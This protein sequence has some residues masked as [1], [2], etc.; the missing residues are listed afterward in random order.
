M[1]YT[2]RV[3]K[4]E[5]ENSN[6]KGFVSITFDRSF[7][8]KNIALKESSKGNLYL[9]MP[10]FKDYQTE[11]YVSFYSFKDGD[12]RKA[13]TEQVI[14]AYQMI[15]A[16]KK[17]IDIE[18]TWDEEELYYAL[19]VTPIHGSNTFKAE[20]AIKI[21]DIFVVQQLR[22]IQGWNGKTFVGMPQ[23]ENR[24]KQEKED[25]AHPVNADFKK[26]LEKAIIDDYHNKLERQKQNYNHN[27][28][29]R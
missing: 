5:K 12:F 7:C 16:D 2:I 1:D 6:L 11:E 10:K 4:V 17:M 26:E 15:A 22:I 8:A 20:A 25:I 21:Q 29:D 3:Y 27:K 28:Y 24:Q 14:D 9:E 18:K 13:V 23:R 19:N